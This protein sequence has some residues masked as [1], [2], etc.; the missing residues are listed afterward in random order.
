MFI[1]QFIMD[2]LF[3][4]DRLA[5]TLIIEKVSNDGRVSSDTITKPFGSWQHDPVYLPLKIAVS[6]YDNYDGNLKDTGQRLIHMYG[7]E[8]GLNLKYYFKMQNG[9]WYL[10]KKSDS[11][12]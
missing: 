3:Q 5:D 4:T 1:Y 7:V 6:T 10:W 9:I 8:S 11:S 12:T 2:S